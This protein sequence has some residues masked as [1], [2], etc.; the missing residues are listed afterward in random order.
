M[1]SKHMIQKSKS[2][3]K[4]ELKNEQRRLKSNQ[5]NQSHKHN[6]KS[7]N[8]NMDIETDN[9]IDSPKK[10]KHSFFKRFILFN[11]LVLLILSTIVITINLKIFLKLSRE[12]L[13]NEP[14]IVLDSEKNI[15]AKIGAER[16]RENVSIDQIPENLK[17][18]YVSIE[19]QRY[20]KHHGVDIKR[21]ASAAFNF[22]KNK[23]SATFGGSTITQ[24]LVK[25]LT[26]R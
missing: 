26:R 18:A 22:I 15:I 4:H 1:K 13:K 5:K 9:Q 10:K 25:N 6:V 12:M 19:D 11:V 3:N 2:K 14:S 16:I 21:T 23:G 17:N 7:R 8:E 24:Q 20:F